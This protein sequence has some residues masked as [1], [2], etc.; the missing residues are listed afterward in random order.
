MG[1]GDKERERQR[2][3]TATLKGAEV[4][5]DLDLSDGYSRFE[6]VERIGSG[7]K[8][9]SRNDWKEMKRKGIKEA[10]KRMFP[11]RWEGATKKIFLSC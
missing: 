8:G 5:R 7:G 2:D 1:K 3:H 11:L 6:K 9:N 10:T 4:T